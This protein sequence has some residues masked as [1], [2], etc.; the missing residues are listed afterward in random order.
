MVTFFSRGHEFQ[1]PEW[2]TYGAL[3]AANKAY[4]NTDYQTALEKFEFAKRSYKQY[5]KPDSQVIG[6][7]NYGLYLS[8]NQLHRYERAQQHLVLAAHDHPTAAWL[9]ADQLPA[10]EEKNK[11]LTFSYHCQQS[12]AAIILGDM[13]YENGDINSACDYYVQADLMLGAE[14]NPSVVSWCE[15]LL[16][17]RM[18]RMLFDADSKKEAFDIWKKT[19]QKTSFEDIKKHIIDHLLHVIT[20]G[21]VDAF[22][23]WGEIADFSQEV[24]RKRCLSFLKKFI[25]EPD[26]TNAQIMPVIDKLLPYITGYDD[27]IKDLLLQFYQRVGSEKKEEIYHKIEQILNSVTK[28]NGHW[29]KE[30][31]EFLVTQSHV[32][33]S[34]FEQCS[35][36]LKKGIKKNEIVNGKDKA[37]ISYLLKQLAEKKEFEPYLA[38][39]KKN[40][41]WKKYQ[42]FLVEKKTDAELIELHC[43]KIYSDQYDKV[44][45]DQKITPLI[46]RILQGTDVQA[47]SKAIDLI[48][49]LT[50]RMVFFDQ[51]DHEKIVKLL[52]GLKLKHPDKKDTIEFLTYA[53]NDLLKLRSNTDKPQQQIALLQNMLPVAHIKSIETKNTPNELRYSKHLADLYALMSVLCKEHNFQ[54]RIQF[55]QD[56]CLLNAETCMHGAVTAYSLLSKQTKDPNIAQASALRIA[57]IALHDVDVFTEF[58]QDN[59]PFSYI[60]D[61]LTDFVYNNPHSINVRFLL[62]K[63]YADGIIQEV[64][65]KK[66]CVGKNLDRAITELEVLREYKYGYFKLAE[67][68]IEKKDYKKAIAVCLEGLAHTKNNLLT[69]YAAEAALMSGDIKAA[70]DMLTYLKNKDHE[71]N[72]KNQRDMLKLFILCKEGTVTPSQVVKA[73]E[74]VPLSIIHQK[75]IKHAQR[76]LVQQDINFLSRVA[77]TLT[78]K[79]ELLQNDIQVLTKLGALCLHASDIDQSNYQKG[80]IYLEKAVENLSIEAAHI[81]A[82]DQRFVTDK[83]R[84]NLLINTIGQ[85]ALSLKDGLK[86]FKHKLILEEFKSHLL[87]QAYLITYNV[88]VRQT[89]TTNI[90]LLSAG[91]VIAAENAKA[92]NY[93]DEPDICYLELLQQDTVVDGKTASV[94]ITKLIEEIFQ[95]ERHEI[96]KLKSKGEKELK[97]LGMYG[98]QCCLVRCYIAAAKKALL[99]GDSEKVEEYLDSA[100]FYVTDLALTTTEIVAP[101]NNAKRVIAFIKTI[102]ELTQ[103]NKQSGIKYYQDL[104]EVLK[105]AK[106]LNSTDW[107]SFG[108]EAASRMLVAAKKDRD[109]VLELAAF[110]ILFFV[111]RFDKKAQTLCLNQIKNIETLLR[112]EKNNN[113]AINQIPQSLIPEILKIGSKNKCKEAWKLAINYFS[114]VLLKSKDSSQQ[115]FEKALFDLITIYEWASDGAIDLVNPETEEYTALC[116]VCDEQIIKLKELCK[117]KESKQVISKIDQEE[118]EKKLQLLGLGCEKEYKPAVEMLLKYYSRMFN[119]EK[120]KKKKNRESIEFYKKALE[121]VCYIASKIN[122]DCVKCVKNSNNQNVYEVLYDMSADSLMSPDDPSVKDYVVRMV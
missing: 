13:A 57:E 112:K 17:C 63:L 111:A 64:N 69:I 120:N 14:K 42:E 82:Q 109:E 35:I 92:I 39:L 67:C 96:L 110:D 2:K 116:Q 102:A 25:T 51:A 107:I 95:Q 61:I 45:F 77:Q 101:G 122:L 40:N 100:F 121:R 47:Q 74:K 60:R 38:Q 70:K 5:Q 59:D 117:T 54:N 89:E 11:L 68:Y 93:A 75:S 16:E 91:C 26:H 97:K 4:A 62:A 99:A 44:D 84:C 46:L 52:L 98:V 65:G 118:I 80:I 3:C 86:T 81:L 114:Q 36:L 20:S 31:L 37:A 115:E 78:Q 18:A 1:A 9:Y 113:Q 34:Q 79:S 28:N 53:L 6:A 90:H 43:Q 33:R 8:N 7:I 71:E 66:T 73:L 23:A 32:D 119:L 12:P 48:T 24:T 55:T 87:A 105:K 94:S 30:K 19:F 108:Y 56:F 27:A 88:L 103:N 104:V 83:G 58:S 41:V 106:I 50:Y 49:W 72:I 85:S 76:Y 29:F 10:G 21:D 22:Q 15:N